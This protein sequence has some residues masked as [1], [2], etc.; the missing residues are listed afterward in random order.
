MSSAPSGPTPRYIAIEGP[1]RVGKSSL[2]RIL[3]QKSGARLLLEPEE[4]PHLEA[5]YAGEPGAAFR[6]QMHFLLQRYQQLA[7]L[8]PGRPFMPLVADYIFEKDKI[9]AYINLSDA[10]LAVYNQY[11]EFL[12][13]QIALPDL[14]IYL[15]ATPAVLRER[16]ER[17]N[18]PREQ[19]VSDEY[20][21]EVVKA[22]D[23]FFFRYNQTDLLVVNTSEIDFIERDADMRELLKRLEEPVAGTQYYL[24]LGE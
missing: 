3:A 22:Y 16:L 24:P 14:V 4:N 19:R 9:F 2:A 15:Q 8:G 6:T 5:F 7:P 21:A 18:I 17:K 20:L 13:P 23:H 12:Q 1:I 11:Y 10:E